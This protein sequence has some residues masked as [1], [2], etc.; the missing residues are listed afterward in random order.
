MQAI[1]VTRHSGITQ[2]LV[3]S[4]TL[5]SFV[6]CSRFA[7]KKWLLMT[8]GIPSYIY[9]VSQEESARLR[10]SVP[11]VKV[12][13]YNPK[14]LYPKLNGYGDNGQRKIGASCVSKYC[15]LHS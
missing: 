4:T 11:Y 8:F 7:C 15:N 12:Y 6:C 14:H 5:L 10:E 1:D 13:R 9:G 3:P 2:Q